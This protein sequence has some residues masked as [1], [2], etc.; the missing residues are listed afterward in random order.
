MGSSPHF[1]KTQL[2]SHLVV[3]LTV[4]FAAN[5]VKCVFHPLE[6]RRRKARLLDQHLPFFPC[7]SMGWVNTFQNATVASM[8]ECLSHKQLSTPLLSGNAYLLGEIMIILS[9]YVGGNQWGLLN[10]L[11][12][13]CLRLDSVERKISLKGSLLCERCV[14]KGLCFSLTAI[15]RW[16]SRLSAHR[17]GTTWFWPFFIL[18]Q[19]GPYH[20][21]GRA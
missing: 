1:V 14:K 3:T 10:R 13:F 21:S 8:C 20:K 2:C 7:S 12:I 9:G 4:N 11:C 18:A 16:E 17:F 6:D 19:R 15:V 5:A